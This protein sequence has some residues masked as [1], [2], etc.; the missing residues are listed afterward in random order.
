MGGDAVWGENNFFSVKALE[1]I[2]MEND[3]GTLNVF[4]VT[5]DVIVKIIPVCTTSL[6]SAAA[7]NI[8]LGVIGSTQAMIANTV[9]TAIDAREIWHDATPDAEVEALSVAREYII[10]DGNDVILT[11]SAQIDTGVIA[12]YCDWAPLSV[13]GSVV[14]V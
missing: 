5:G 11:L 10:T 2:T 12:F 7:A 8:S 6:T 9:A 13:D 14:P 4:T 3:S 1:T